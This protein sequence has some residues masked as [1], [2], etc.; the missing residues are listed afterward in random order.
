MKP[1]RISARTRPIQRTALLPLAPARQTH[2][3]PGSG[4]ASGSY[5][6]VFPRRSGLVAKTLTVDCAAVTLGI[7]IC[8]GSFGAIGAV[9]PNGTAGIAVVQQ[10]SQ[11]F[12][13]VDAGVGDDVFPDK[14]VGI[15]DVD[16]V[17]AAFFVQ[18][19]SISF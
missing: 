15:V 18:R 14:L 19:A 7:Q 11:G 17:L 13:V 16:V 6:F 9:G 8:F 4:F 1:I 10:L 12:G 5:C 3:R 2:A